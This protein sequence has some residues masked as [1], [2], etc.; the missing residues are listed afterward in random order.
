MHLGVEDAVGQL[1]RS[2][3]ELALELQ[4]LGTTD[5]TGHGL[6]PVAGEPGL[7]QRLVRD[8]PGLVEPTDQAQQ[9]DLLVER[10]QA[11]QVAEFFKAF[12][13]G[14]QVDFFAQGD[15]VVTDDETQGVFL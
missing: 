5:A 2:L 10:G 8:L 3:V 12:A 9:G 13:G 4:N 6:L 15:G 14:Q 11:A 1:A 7:A